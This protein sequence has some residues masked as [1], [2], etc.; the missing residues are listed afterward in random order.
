MT[1]IKKEQSLTF[2][3]TT[4]VIERD[5]NIYYAP[6]FKTYT[7]AS[8][9]EEWLHLFNTVCLPDANYTNREASGW[10]PQDR[11]LRVRGNVD[12]F[13]LV[14]EEGK[15]LNYFI[16]DRQVTYQ[17]N[18]EQTVKH[19][20]YAFFINNVRQAGQ[21]SV[22][23]DVEPDHFTNVFFL[24]NEDTL[25]DNYDAFNK[26]MSNCYVARQHY[27]RVKWSPRGT[28]NYV[29]TQTFEETNTNQYN[30]TFTILKSLIENGKVGAYDYQNIN[31]S[32]EDFDIE[33]VDVREY[34]TSIT[35][36]MQIYGQGHVGEE[37]V[38][39]TLQVPCVLLEEANLDLFSQVEETFKYKRQLRDYKEPLIYDMTDLTEQDK[40]E[41]KYG[42]WNSLSNE[43]KIKAVKLS[44]AFFHVISASDLTL[45]RKIENQSI[46]NFV[47]YRSDY[48]EEIPNVDVT[49]SLYRFVVPI[50]KNTNMLSDNIKIQC[51][52]IIDNFNIKY[53]GAYF[54]GTIEEINDYTFVSGTAGSGTS[55]FNLLVNFSRNKGLYCCSQLIEAPFSSYVLS[56]YVTKEASLLNHIRFYSD[57]IEINSK[58]FFFPDFYSGFAGNDN[59]QVSPELMAKIVAYTQ[60]GSN[61]LSLSRSGTTYTVN[62]YNYNQEG[63]VIDNC[64]AFAMFLDTVEDIGGILDLK[65]KVKNPKTDY[66]DVVLSFNPYSFWSISYLGEIEVPLNKN[67]YYENEVIEY[68]FFVNCSD[69]MVYTVLPKY[70]VE[71]KDYN[72]YSEQLK[73]SLSCSLSI[74][75]DKLSDYVIA[76]SAQMKNQFA[77]NDTNLG[78]GLTDTFTGEAVSVVGGSAI[79]GGMMGGGAGAGMGAIMGTVQQIGKGISQVISHSKN[80][81]IISMTQKAKLSDMGHLPDTLKQ[82]G[83]N[84]TNDLIVN[85]IGLYKNHYKIDE[86]SYNSICKYLERFGYLV[87]IY[88][89]LK[90][91]NRVGW[92]YIELISFDYD[93]EITVEQENGIRKIFQNGVTLLHDKNYLTQGHNFETILEEEV[94]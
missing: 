86:V 63:K 32:L 26:R 14:S 15:A 22:E 42:T 3:N 38:D 9:R 79:K 27:D 21:G 93:T 49:T 43:L 36:D 12:D 18:N 28:V 24:H 16:L 57:R 53:S 44:L 87:N 5:K 50:F 40:I 11:K 35:I 25:V 71:G 51:R 68:Q 1:V 6:L 55:T 13:R 67:N 17:N 89:A 39:V 66:Y 74:N 2:Y 80:K 58:P 23:L 4:G 47:D 34:E 19:Y 77:V 48:H 31:F 84:L 33:Y 46:T 64:P 69:T 61:T 41:L 81:D 59:L 83:T 7:Y 10:S 78:Y 45:K 30:A 54:N 88:D 60:S 65:D 8:V 72:Y 82:V 70:T 75:N 20:Y 73:L 85:E 56:A 92:N 52:A 91:N 94:M 29:K 62:G 90:V 76:N 37:T